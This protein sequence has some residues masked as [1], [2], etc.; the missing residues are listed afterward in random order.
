MTMK[1]NNTLIFLGIGA[2]VVGYYFWNKNRQK[3]I[4]NQ[5]VQPVAEEDEKGKIVP[6]GGGG[7]GGRGGFVA[8]PTVTPTATTTPTVVIATNPSSTPASVSVSQPLTQPNVGNLLAPLSQ[9][10]PAPSSPA[11]APSSPAPAPSSPAPAP[12]SPAPAPSSPA[13]ALPQIQ[14]PKVN[15]AKSVFSGT[16][17]RNSYDID[18]NFDM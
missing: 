13:P 11:P 18:V 12:S 17:G 5:Q 3:Q 8:T 2:L 14:M 4:A 6:V 9:L 1:N 15:L 7:G 16:D 10:A